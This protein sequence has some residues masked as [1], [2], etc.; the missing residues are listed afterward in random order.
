VK[1]RVGVIGTGFGGRVVAPVFGALDQ[2]EVMEVVSARDDAAVAAMCERIDIDLVCVHS[3]PFL[4]AAHVRRAIAGGHAVLCDKPFGRDAIEAET[5]VGAAVAADC[6]N[7]CNFEFRY[8]PIR[9]LIRMLVTDGAVGA[10]EHVSWTHYSSGSRVPLRRHGWLF[11]RALGGGW[12]NAW[13]SHAVDFL[14]WTFGEIT[15][16]TAAC[17]VTITERPDAEGTLHTCDAEDAFSA[18]LVA[19]GATVTIDTSFAA[20]VA[21]APRLTVV[22]SD[23]ALECVADGRVVVRKA[24]G[25]TTE[26]MQPATGGDRHL[27]PM[28]RWATVVRDALFDGIAPPDAPTFVDG[29]E[30]A[31]V[32]DRLRAGRGPGPTP[33]R[34]GPLG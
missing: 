2:C 15:D 10:P 5:L 23:G 19:G 13:G 12:V 28:R 6:V 27:E 11:D 29:F 33:G 25:T 1:L 22:G 30:C 21:L 17:R 16:A 34:L 9:Q 24:D 7:L 8:H 14:R 32:L 20:S 31:R 18:S 26:H 3:P 4:H